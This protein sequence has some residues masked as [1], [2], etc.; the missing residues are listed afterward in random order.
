MS[1]DHT[2]SVVVVAYNAEATIRGCLQALERQTDR[3]FE[4]I[5]VDSSEDR[6]AEIVGKEF[7][8]ATLLRSERRLAPGAARNRG[9]SAA[10]GDVVAFVDSDCIARPDWVAILRR[11]HRELPMAAIGGAVEPANPDSVVGWGA[12]L[13]EFSAWLPRGKQRPMRDIPTCNLSFKRWALQQFGPFCESG[14]CSDTALNWKLTAAGHAP[15][16]LPELR[17]AHFNLTHLRRFLRKQVMHGHAFASMRC[18]ERSLGRRA[19]ALLGAGALLLPA[20]LL[21]RLARRLAGSSVWRPALRSLPVIVIGFGAW[22]CGEAIGYVR[23][24]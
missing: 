15:L 8:F 23:G 10:K 14:Y 18:R 11:A 24:H 9:V 4:L 7:P 6:T 3:D 20:L 13:C 12:Y 5:V 17:V 22:S 1:N 19:R 2:F 21:G 16:F